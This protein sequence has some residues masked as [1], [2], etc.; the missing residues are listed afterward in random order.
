MVAGLAL[1][2]V[3]AMLYMSDEHRQPLFKARIQY[4]HPNSIIKQ[5]EVSHGFLRITVELGVERPE[6]AKLVPLD[7]V[8]HVHNRSQSLA[9]NTL[10][11]SFKQQLWGI[12]VRANVY[13]VQDGGRCNSNS[14]SAVSEWSALNQLH[15][16]EHCLKQARFRGEDVDLVSFK[17]RLVDQL[18]LAGE[19]DVR[20]T[21]NS[22]LAG[23]ELNALPTFTLPGNLFLVPMDNQTIDHRTVRAMAFW[24]SEN[25]PAQVAVVVASQLKTPTLFKLHSVQWRTVT[26]AEWFSIRHR[27]L[28]LRLDKPILIANKKNMFIGLFVDSPSIR[29][30]PTST[31][32]TYFQPVRP[33]TRDQLYRSATLKM[34]A[35]VGNQV[36]LFNVT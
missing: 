11:K 16:Y 9:M 7:V 26:V 14:S 36:P 35:V 2:F 34:Q 13:F 8:A 5:V 28:E 25:L 30:A 6:H 22:L 18:L 33:T 27:H 17:W 21:K 24:G 19:L 12:D 10:V 31:N 23:V 32:T 15:V 20:Q 1:G 4:R 3:L 29:G